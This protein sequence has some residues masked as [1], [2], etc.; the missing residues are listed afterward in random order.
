MA[1]VDAAG[2]ADADAFTDPAALLDTAGLLDPVGLLAAEVFELP[3]PEPLLEAPE[4]VQVPNPDWQ[5]V[6]Q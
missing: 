2:L 3:E 1:E 4:E 5:P 6:P